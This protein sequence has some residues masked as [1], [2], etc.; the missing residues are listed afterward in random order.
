MRPSNKKSIT[1]FSWAQYTSTLFIRR[2]SIAIPHLGIT[3]V[4]PSYPFSELTRTTSNVVRTEAHTADGTQV[5]QHVHPDARVTYMTR[6][7]A[8]HQRHDAALPLHGLL[9]MT[10]RPT[11]IS[12]CDHGALG[13]PPTERRSLISIQPSIYDDS[14]TK[15]SKHIY[16]ASCR[17]I[18]KTFCLFGTLQS[19][20]PACF[21]RRHIQESRILLAERLRSITAIR[22]LF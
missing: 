16:Y 19:L 3:T 13:L 4:N 7:N 18:S 11:N 8:F 22:T 12:S 1:G 2:P 17:T 14:E 9:P 15:I 6:P 21:G 10:P 20:L 5:N